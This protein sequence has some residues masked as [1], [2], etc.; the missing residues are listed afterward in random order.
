MGSLFQYLL[1]EKHF[2]NAYALVRTSAHYRKDITHVSLLYTLLLRIAQYDYTKHSTHIVF[3]NP[4]LPEDFAAAILASPKTSRVIS[5]LTRHPILPTMG[6][7]AAALAA[8]QA[9]LNA[10]FAV[11]SEDESSDEG[12][13]ADPA[14]DAFVPQVSFHRYTLSGVGLDYSLTT[15]VRGF[16]NKLYNKGRTPRN[17]QIY[18]TG[19]FW[20]LWLTVITIVGPFYIFYGFTFMYTHLYIFPLAVLARVALV[21]G[22]RFFDLTARQLWVRLY[23]LL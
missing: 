4:A 20:C 7:S 9:S 15:P 1:I 11:Y 12:Q 17:K 21:A 5:G 18:R 2:V 19:V 23:H 6:M 8:R 10:A 13:T 14:E 3:I 22:A 16:L